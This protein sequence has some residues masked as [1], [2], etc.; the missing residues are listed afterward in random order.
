MK[1][2]SF[3]VFSLLGLVGIVLVKGGPIRRI[4]EVELFCGR[5]TSR[6]SGSDIAS[7]NLRVE[8]LLRYPPFS[9]LFVSLISFFGDVRLG[10]LGG[11]EERLL[12]G[13]PVLLPSFLSVPLTVDEDEEDVADS[14]SAG[15]PRVSGTF[16]SFLRGGTPYRLV[17][18]GRL[19]G[20]LSCLVC[21]GDFAGT[22]TPGE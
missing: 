18:G 14:R 1:L 16:K 21:N 7:I 11:G 17:T 15:S 8:S 5:G 10:P 12:P 9:C 4:G 13:I 22:E 3:G 6:I 19:R 20:G 2:S